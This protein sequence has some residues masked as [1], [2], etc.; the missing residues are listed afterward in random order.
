MD[1][2]RGS[3]VAPPRQIRGNKRKIRA[4]I[5]LG[6]NE[7]ERVT[8]VQQAMQFLKDV[9]GITVLECS[10]LYETE[11]FDLDSPWFVNAVAAVDTSLTARELLEVCNDIE[12]RLIELYRQS[13]DKG[14]KNRII[15]LDILFYGREVMD[16]GDLKIPHP[17]LH[18]RAFALVPLL[19]I[20]PDIR[21]PGLDRSVDELHHELPNP[22]QVFLYGTRVV[23]KE[24]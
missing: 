21:H 8:Y 5:A 20:A 17:R 1:I 4:Y 3:T 12:Q 13:H 10:S 23:D 18:R 16:L 6:S 22:E 2:H 19:E 9:D 15:D 7:G 11:V 24:D 14:P